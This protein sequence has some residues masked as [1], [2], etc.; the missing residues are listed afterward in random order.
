MGFLSP[1]PQ[2]V[3][4]AVGFLSPAPQ[5]VPQAAGFLSPVPQAEAA[6]AWLVLWNRFFNDIIVS[7][8]FLAR[9]RIFQVSAER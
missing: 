3:P 5:A 1:A 8:L 6:E 4:Q 9:G 2:A 7:S